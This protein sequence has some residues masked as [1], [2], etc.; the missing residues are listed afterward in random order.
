MQA[1][2]TVDV[3]NMNVY[4]EVADAQHNNYFILEDNYSDAATTVP[5]QTGESSISHVTVYNQLHVFPS[6]NTSNMYSR[7]GSTSSTTTE[8]GAY[9]TL[10]KK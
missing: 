10:Q 7:M 5:Q 4:D 3:R 8:P 9:D 2:T 6:P 1:E